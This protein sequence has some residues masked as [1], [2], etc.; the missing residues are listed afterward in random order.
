LNFSR[1]FSRGNLLL[2]RRPQFI[3]GQLKSECENP[4]PNSKQLYC[5]WALVLPLN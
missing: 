2:S 5:W 1:I 4:E 3:S